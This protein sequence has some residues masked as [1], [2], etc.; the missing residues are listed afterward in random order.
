[1]GRP[2]SKETKLAEQI[3][4]SVEDHYFNPSIVGRYL[5][6]NPVYTIDRVMEIIAYTIRSAKERYDKELEH[7]VTSEG[8]ILANNL[9]KAMNKVKSKVEFSNISL[10]K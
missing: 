9:D 5:V 4:N 3:S 10:P 1:M 7:G 2:Q 6:D 8:L